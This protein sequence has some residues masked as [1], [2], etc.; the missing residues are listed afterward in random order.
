MHYR[1]ENEGVPRVNVSISYA[2]Q[3]WYT[4]LTRKVTPIIQLEER[5]LVAAGMSMLWVPQNPRAYPVYGYKGKSGYSLMN[6]FDPNVGSA[7]VVA[8]LPEDRLVWVDQIRDNFCTLQERTEGKTAEE[9]VAETPCKRPSNSSILDYV[10]VSGTLSGLDTGV[11]RPSRDPDDD[12]TLTE[13]MK[14]RK[15]LEDKKRE[16]DAQAAA[17][18]S[19]KKNQ[20]LWVQLPHPL[21]QRLTWVCL[22]RNLAIVWRKYSK[23]P[24]LHD[25]DYLCFAAASSKFACSGSKIDISK[26][27]PPTSPPSK[28]LDLSPPNPDPKGK[29]KE[30]DVEVDKTERVVENVVAGSGRDDVH[31]EGVETEWESSEIMN[32]V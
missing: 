1:S 17:V 13:M 16:L 22:A 9:P 10:V 18:L 32:V 12:A 8:A 5:A 7:M 31:A 11:K 14:K 20:N 15:I 6:V 29:G 2:D 28:P 19:K 3:D 23:L 30:D 27:T 21:S 4:T 24:L 26:I 25:Y